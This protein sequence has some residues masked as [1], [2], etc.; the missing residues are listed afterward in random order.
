MVLAARH[1]GLLSR[2]L[3]VPLFL[4]ALRLPRRRG[5]VRAEQFAHGD[6]E[7]LLANDPVPL[8]GDV[9]RRQRRLQRPD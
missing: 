1:G 9:P 4:V 8:C 5:D 2:R 3:G 7:L 6:V